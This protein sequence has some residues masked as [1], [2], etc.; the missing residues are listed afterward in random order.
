MGHES[1][2]PWQRKAA[3]YVRTLDDPSASETVKHNAADVLCE[4]LRGGRRRFGPWNAQKAYD[5]K[6]AHAQNVAREKLIAR[7][8][9]QKRGEEELRRE[10][11]RLRRIYDDD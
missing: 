2:R 7:G 9:E 4:L 10:A 3:T 5:S 8:I 11:R 1:T 6:C